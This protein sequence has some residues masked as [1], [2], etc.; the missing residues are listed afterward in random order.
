MTLKNLANA[1][2]TSD[3][4]SPLGK[5]S[6]SQ[7][8]KGKLILQD[9]ADILNKPNLSTSDIERI[10]NLSTEYYKKIPKSFG[11][12]I[13][14]SDVLINT[15]DRLSE[16]L[17]ILQFYKD[18]LSIKELF[19]T[20]LNIDEKYKQLN[21]DIGV[22][23]P[24]T[25][26]Y[27]EIVD[28]VKHSQSNHHNVDLEV[29][30]IY[31]VNQKNAPKFDDSVGNVRE[32]FHG[33]GSRNLVAILSSHLKLPNTLKGVHITGAMFGPGLYF[34]DQ[35]T[36]SSQY[37]N[38]RFGGEANKYDTSFMFLADVALGNIKQV[39][40]SHYFLNPPKGY[41]S[42]EGVEGRY[43]LH[44][45]YIIYKEDRVRLRYIIEFKAHRKRR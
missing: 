35:S 26:K 13:S 34:A 44:N 22:L 1:S 6:E 16:E 4:Q 24:R 27:K 29:V 36:K 25:K 21:C 2:F 45:E 37:S 9:I 3:K 31:T 17:E 30:N 14:S 8:S 15:F 42:V 5:L 11:S 33:T 43:L 39:E 12:N 7:I 20:Q 10:T 19:N 38:S 23:S 41:D 18:A 28:Y 32:L 40:E